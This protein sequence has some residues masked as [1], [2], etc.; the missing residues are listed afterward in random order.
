MNCN[1]GVNLTIILVLLTTLTGVLFTTI[2]LQ[3][4]ANAISNNNYNNYVGGNV[5]SNSSAT[6][7]A[8]SS[9]LSPP[10]PQGIVN[11]GITPN[12][13]ADQSLLIIH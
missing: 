9:V 5:S 13:I 3:G 2:A 11:V 8:N 4:Y 6:L 10:E 1:R 12:E 7:G